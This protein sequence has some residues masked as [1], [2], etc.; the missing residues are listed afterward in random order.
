MSNIK[1]ILRTNVPWIV[2]VVLL[3]VFRIASPSFMTG[4][5]LENILVQNS[6]LLV[7]SFG[8]TVIMMSGGMDLSVGYQISI[9]GVVVGMCLNKGVP[10]ALCILLAILIGVGYCLMNCLLS[11]LLK[12]PLLVVSLATMTIGQGLSFIISGAYSY[13]GLPESFRWFGQGRLAGIS[14]PV[15]IALIMFIITS[16]MLQRTYYGRYVM[17]IGGNEEASNLAG[18]NVKKMR[19]LIAVFEG[20][21]VGIGTVMLVG[22]LGSA[23]SQ[24]GPGTEFTVL[25]AVILGGVSIRGGEGKVSGTVAGILILAILSNGMQLAGLTTYHQYVAKGLIM[26]LA[27]AIDIL[28]LKANQNRDSAIV[29]NIESDNND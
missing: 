26:L 19:I 3:V 9:I 13:F 16:V 23:Q 7:I 27:I 10:V 24:V 28:N 6:Y 29:H 8:I 1:N 15:I 4:K 22:K 21:C 25:T 18:I 5:N 12:L 11:G 14:V 20:I 2:L 17:A